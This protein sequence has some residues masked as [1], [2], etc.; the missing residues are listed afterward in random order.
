MRAPDII[1]E[2]DA[3]RATRADR[4][5]RDLCES[6]GIDQYW[7]LAHRLISACEGEMRKEDVLRLLVKRLKRHDCEL[8][9]D[10]LI[11]RLE[12]RG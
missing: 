3:E 7:Y 5:I 9:A 11:E 6:R 4:V 10:L 2:Y 12:R 1:F 8:L